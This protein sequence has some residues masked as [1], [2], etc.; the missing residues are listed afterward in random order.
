MSKYIKLLERIKSLESHLGVVFSP[1]ELEGDYAEHNTGECGELKSINRR[2]G[3][4][5]QKLNIRK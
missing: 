2:L 5:E 1:K 4:V 3:E